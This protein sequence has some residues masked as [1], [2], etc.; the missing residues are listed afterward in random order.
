MMIMRMEKM[1]TV[2]T[3]AGRR[4]GHARDHGS[5]TKLIKIEREQETEKERGS[6]KRKR[7]RKKS[8]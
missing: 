4:N 3:I 2:T 5:I 8:R 7:K 1:M 6:E